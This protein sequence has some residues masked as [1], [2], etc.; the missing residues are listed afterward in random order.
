[1]GYGF[2]SP[3]GVLHGIVQDFWWGPTLWMAGIEKPPLASGG[4]S[5]LK[6]QRALGTGTIE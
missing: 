1:M 3:I 2:Q 4:A 6:K 5:E